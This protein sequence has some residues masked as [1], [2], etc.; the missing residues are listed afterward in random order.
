MMMFVMFSVSDLLFM[1][2]DHCALDLWVKY[3]CSHSIFCSMVR[4]QSLSWDAAS[5]KQS[6]ALIESRLTI[7]NPTDSSFSG[8]SVKAEAIYY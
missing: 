1:L 8:C 4:F 7:K 6:A 3:T 2:S 5:L